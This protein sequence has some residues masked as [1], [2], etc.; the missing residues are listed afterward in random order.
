MGASTATGDGAETE[1]AP[2]MA[3]GASMA[4]AQSKS[5]EPVKQTLSSS[6]SVLTRFARTDA[7]EPTLGVSIRSSAACMSLD[8]MTGGTPTPVVRQT[9]DQLVSAVVWSTSGSPGACSA[10]VSRQ[11]S[12]SCSYCS[13]AAARRFA[14]WQMSAVLAGGRARLKPGTFMGKRD[15][16]LV[17]ARRCRTRVTA[18][19]PLPCE[20]VISNLRQITCRRQGRVEHNGA[21]RVSS[22]GGP[23]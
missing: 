1:S 4:T 23:S 2:A 12:S 22:L 7:I 16:L 9:R 5:S 3:L 21:P 6:S 11:I 14:I 20:E 10:A 13:V 18:R 17:F 8:G 15:S 19:G